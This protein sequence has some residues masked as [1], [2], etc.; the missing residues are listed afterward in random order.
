MQK[1]SQKQSKNKRVLTIAL[2]S[3]Y[4]FEGKEIAQFNTNKLEFFKGRKKPINYYT[5]TAQ[6]FYN[7]E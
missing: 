7:M 6:S 4:F 3:F 2:N 5:Y 1:N